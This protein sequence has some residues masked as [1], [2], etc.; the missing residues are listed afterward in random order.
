MGRPEGGR[1]SQREEKGELLISKGIV[2]PT[3][4]VEPVALVNSLSQCLLLLTTKRSSVVDLVNYYDWLQRQFCQFAFVQCDSVT[5]IAFQQSL[6][7]AV[8]RIWGKVSTQSRNT[9]TKPTVKGN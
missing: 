2:G 1:T 8:L 7:L 3:W 6:A 4:T 5:Y 9:S